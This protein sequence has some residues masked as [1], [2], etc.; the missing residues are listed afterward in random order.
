MACRVCGGRDVEL[1]L[2]L[3]DQ[4]HRNCRNSPTGASRISPSAPASATTARSSRS[5]TRSRRRACSATTPTSRGHRRRWSGV[6]ARPRPGSWSGTASRPRRRHRQQRRHV[7]AAVRA[8]RPAPLR[9]RLLSDGV[10]ARPSTRSGC[11]PARP[12]AVSPLSVRSIFAQCR[13]RPPPAL[14][15]FIHD[16]PQRQVTGYQARA[17]GDPIWVPGAILL[18]RWLRLPTQRC[19]RAISRARRGRKGSDSR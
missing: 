18:R 8:L 16:E 9:R 7:A 5:I 17:P 15:L 10:T 14:S 3:T 19:R 1:S 12:Q 4:P 11:G 13:G 2:D 6:A